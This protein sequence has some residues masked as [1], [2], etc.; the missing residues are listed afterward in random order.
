MSYV[1]S[2]EVINPY[3]VCLG[4]GLNGE[5]YTPHARLTTFAFSESFRY[6]FYL[7]TYDTNG[8]DYWTHSFRLYM[9]DLIE[10]YVRRVY[11]VPDDI[12]IAVNLE[13]RAWVNDHALDR[14]SQGT[15]ETFATE[16]EA[17]EYV[18]SL[19]NP[20]PLITFLDPTNYMHSPLFTAAWRQEIDG[21]FVSRTA[22]LTYT[23]EQVSLYTYHD[24]ANF[25]ALFFEIT[26]EEVLDKITYELNPDAPQNTPQYEPSLDCETYIKATIVDV[27]GPAGPVEIDIDFTGGSI[28]GD[29]TV[30]VVDGDPDVILT[31][32]VNGDGAVTI[33]DNGNIIMSNDGGTFFLNEFGNVGFYA[34]GDASLTADNQVQL[35][36][37]QNS[38]TVENGSL[39]I[40]DET[41]S[42]T[43]TA[44]DIN[45]L[46]DLLD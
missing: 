4:E 23:G 5:D 28:P 13:G 26:P 18:D 17:L 34:N 3:G 42:A 45:N 20:D 2:T 36:V 33:H 40:R 22:E 19:G 43:L 38:V 7:G 31:E 30:T 11:N 6:R 1:V 35:G 27:D 9:D 32:I 12:A 46:K 15:Q 14:P 37:G 25:F 44:E 29:V 8:D 41:G 21:V 16:A 39:T 10:D 24:F